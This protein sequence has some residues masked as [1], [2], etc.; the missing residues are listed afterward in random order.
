LGSIS[1]LKKR[2]V[3]FSEEKKQKTFASWARW[4]AQLRA[5]GAKVFCFF[6]SKKKSFLH[7]SHASSQAAH[8]CVMKKPAPKR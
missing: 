1:G 7:Q 2:K 6:F 5:N 4:N 3:F 8:I